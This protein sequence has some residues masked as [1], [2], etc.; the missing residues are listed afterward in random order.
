[1]K[2]VTLIP[3]YKFWRRNLMTYFCFVVLW[4]KTIY[5]A[6]TMIC[7]HIL[8]ISR[9]LKKPINNFVKLPINVDT[10]KY[11]KNLIILQKKSCYTILCFCKFYPYK[12]QARTLYHFSEKAHIREK[13]LCNF[14]IRGLLTCYIKFNS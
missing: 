1:M 14:R 8:S 12:Q 7:V 10:S 2:N 13:L 9:D 3:N 5:F 6:V 4:Y 11:L